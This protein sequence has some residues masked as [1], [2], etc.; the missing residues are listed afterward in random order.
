MCKSF[1]GL[2]AGLLLLS[3]P[4]S[5]ALAAQPSAHSGPKA[6]ALPFFQIS[7][8]SADDAGGI[9]NGSTVTLTI[10]VTNTG[11]T[12]G[13][14]QAALVI[15]SG[16]DFVDPNPCA[17][18]FYFPIGRPANAKSL[19]GAYLVWPHGTDGNGSGDTLAVGASSTCN[20]RLNVATATGNDIATVTTYRGPYS[21]GSGAMNATQSYLFRTTS[22]P[23]TDMWVAV[24]ASSSSVMVGGTIDYTLTASNAG[25]QTGTNVRTVFNFP[26]TLSVVPK[27]CPGA[28]TL[29]GQ[30]IT[31]NAGNMNYGT[32]ATCVLTGTAQ[33][34]AGSNATVDATISANTTDPNPANNTASST[35]AIVVPSPQA[36]LAAAIS[37]S[38]TSVTPGQDLTFTLKASNLGPSTATSTQLTAGFSSQLQLNS[39]SCVIGAP[40]NSLVWM[41]GTLPSGSTSTC[42]VQ[43]TLRANTTA[44]SIAASDS[45]SSPATDNNASNNGAS[46]IIPVQQQTQAANIAIHLS[47]L[48]AGQSYS[49]G[50]TLIF[51]VTATN[52][53]TGAD[54]AGVVAT[55]H[56]PGGGSLTGF[57]APCGT[58]DASGKLVW[59]IGTLLRNSSATCTVRATVATATSAIAI[60][61]DIDAAAP[62]TDLDHLMDALVVPVHSVPKQVSNSITGAPTTRNS[63]RVKLNGDGSV[64]VFQSQENHLVGSNI[65]SNGQDI[66]RVGSDGKTTM[67]TM[68]AAGHQLI[69]TSSLPAVSGDGGIVAF[70]YN[71][72]AAMQAKDAITTS[73]W[74]GAAGQPKHQVDMGMAGAAPNGAVSGAPSV[75]SAGGAKK[76]VF[77]SAASNLVA[78]DNNGQRDIFL[79][80]PTNPGQATQLVS[81]DNHG[82]QIS[83]DSCEPSLSADGTKVAFT[84]GAPA[85]YGPARQVARKDLTT[86]KLEI[87]SATTTGGFAN[88]DS[89]EPSINADGSV[90]AFT[91]TASNLDA[92]GAPVGG[93]EA[94]VSMAQSPADGAARV[95][96]RLRSGDGTV[97]NGASEH[98]QLSDD[99]AIAV[100]QTAATNFF[101]QAKALAPACGSVA[102][103]T[104]FFSPAVMA[105]SLCSGSTSNQNPTISGNGTTT[106][107][108]SNAPQAGTVSNNSNAYS[109]G[110]AG[111]NALGVSNLSGDFSG[112]WFDPNQSGQGLVI[113]VTQPDAN[114]TRYLSAIWFVY[115]NGQPTWLLGAAIPK[116]GTGDQA[117]K[118]IVQMDQVGI[119]QGVSFPIGETTAAATLWGSITLT[120][121]DANT[122]TMSWTSTYPGFNSGTMLITHFQ[123]V[124]VPASDPAGAQVKACYSGN[125]KEPTKSGHGFEFEVTSSSAN[126]TPVLAVDWFT[127]TPTGAPVWLYG[128]GL[129]NGNSSQMTLAIVDGTGA[130]FPPRFNPSQITQHA[131]G[132][133]TFTFTDA[134]HAHVTWNSTIPGYGQ[135]QLDLVPT[136]GLDRR[137]CQ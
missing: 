48:V 20:V 33:S 117:G 74:G 110:V 76:L 3:L 86:G 105:S 40:A 19:N 118:V 44:T 39:A 79:I 2:C 124:R 23:T 134:T 97:P 121:T 130:Q 15:P 63:T 119:F 95:I 106:G 128:G 67:E 101:G 89:S 11:S 16:Y 129:I 126:G 102:I 84:I 113:D 17:G 90:I 92:L 116:V 41:V 9:Y 72:A 69:G 4:A 125:W 81:S 94:F 85:L 78:G 62:G 131:W 98:P 28:S 64:A 108:D 80:D 65:N 73:M 30:S 54:A 96:K 38:A 53:S 61:A 21:N 135:G 103:T 13:Q 51:I 5:S 93:R 1:L 22:S 29:G 75:S 66:Y 127:F 45:V 36:D 68:D 77:C 42:T 32:S 8:L 109:E 99:G 82:N 57:N 115:L 58:V 120:F 14:W 112:Q 60:S 87:L 43:A 6:A 35:V 50:Q 114:N 46:V 104:N 37:A 137:T 91:S 71:A 123:Q 12:A 122:G 111:L 88:A 56:L 18:D 24:G 47:D 55:V 133:A 100:M 31:W 10:V 27:N 52:T 136:F 59:Q 70:A 83:G 132:T 49:P 25:R 7:S 34:G 107:F 26:N